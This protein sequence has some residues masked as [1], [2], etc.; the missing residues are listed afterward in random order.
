MGFSVLICGQ[1]ANEVLSEF[2][3]DELQYGEGQCGHSVVHEDVIPQSE[4]R[5]EGQE[6]GDRQDQHDF[7]HEGEV[8]EGVRNPL[9][10]HR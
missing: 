5:V 9:G 6:E 2:V 7:G 3:D 10:Y 4:G 8:H 1:V